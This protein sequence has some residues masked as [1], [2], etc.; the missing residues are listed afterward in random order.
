MEYKELE[1]TIRADAAKIAGED[2][3]WT[4]L[5]VSSQL[6]SI[7]DRLARIGREKQGGIDAS[8][9]KRSGLKVEI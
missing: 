1:E 4:A 9:G 7:A 3:A 8:M 2:R 5:E 6:Q